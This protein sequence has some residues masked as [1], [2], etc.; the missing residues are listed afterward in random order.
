M[1]LRLPEGKPRPIILTAAD[2]LLNTYV[3]FVRIKLQEEEPCIKKNTHIH[4]HMHTYL[5]LHTQVHRLMHA[6]ICIHTR[7]HALIP[8]PAHPG[9]QTLSHTHTHYTLY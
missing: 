2:R 6:H 8:A 9:T 4:T 1:N 3:G 7:T 5:H